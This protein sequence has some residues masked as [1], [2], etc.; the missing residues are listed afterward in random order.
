ML[1]AT[2]VCMCSCKDVHLEVVQLC[3]PH[4]KFADCRP[5]GRS[6]L[7]IP[8]GGPGS[9]GWE[10]FRLALQ[11][12]EDVIRQLRAQVCWQEGLPQVSVVKVLLWPVPDCQQMLLRTDFSNLLWCA[13]QL[14]QQINPTWVTCVQALIEGPELQ[15]L[16]GLENLVIFRAPHRVI[17][18]TP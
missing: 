16:V 18:C 14:F 8:S 10:S 17:S 9:V 7:I 11:R 1:N 2:G 13:S 3:R 5:R 15:S 4:A 6:S 12:V